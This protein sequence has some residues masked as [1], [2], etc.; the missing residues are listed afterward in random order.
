MPKPVEMVWLYRVQNSDGVGPYTGR[1][2]LNLPSTVGHPHTIP[3]FD[4]IT[5]TESELQGKRFA[6]ENMF[7]LL[8]WFGAPETL[9]LLQHHGYDI[10]RIWVPVHAVIF[11]GTQC[12][13]NPSEV[14]ATGE[15]A[16]EHVASAALS[17]AA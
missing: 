7:H 1:V 8:D 17:Y 9:L 14:M 10:V 15:I 3:M 16:W 4:G 6:F 13:Y 2:S 12:V 5:L 11:G